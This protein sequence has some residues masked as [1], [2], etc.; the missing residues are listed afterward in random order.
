MRNNV[1]SLIL[2][3]ST[4][5]IVYLIVETGSYLILKYS[6]ALHF[7]P[8]CFNQQISPYYVFENTPGFKYKDLIK[9]NPDEPE[10]I[11][12]PNGFISESPVEKHKD[13]NTIRIFI[14]GGSTAF[15][16]GQTSPYETIKEYP[17]GIYSFKS[18][19]AGLLQEK[20]KKEFPDKKIEVINA[21]AVKRMLHQSVAYYL[22]TISNFSPD[23]VITIDGNNDVAPICG[24]S[25]YVKGSMALSSYIKL[26]ELTQL[27][28]DKSYFNFINLLNTLKLSNLKKKEKNRGDDEQDALIDPF[29]SAKLS[30]YLIYKKQF[31][32]GSEKLLK[33]I[34]YYNALCTTDDTR[35]I[36]CLQPLLYRQSINK[37]LSVSEKEMQKKF[38]NTNIKTIKVNELFSPSQI[39][40]FIK[41]SQL[42]LKYFI[43]DYLTE[44]INQISTEKGFTYIDMNKEMA[45]V[46]SNQDVFVDYCHLT[47]LGNEIVA[48]SLFEKVSSILN[49]TKD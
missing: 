12:D 19:I 17:K 36:F 24:M 30:E 49:E 4:L 33:L 22:E 9:A 2:L 37:K 13:D 11:V 44:K 26:Y 45:Q 27:V 42:I 39:E 23:V 1:K 43:D 47:P 46:P 5:I 15:G 32:R 8:S 41:G 48:E 40:F 34:K 14:T 7:A 35:F 10:I 31:I 21:C 16:S 6:K 18:S 25:P 38:F 20:L 28:Q 3:L 29:E